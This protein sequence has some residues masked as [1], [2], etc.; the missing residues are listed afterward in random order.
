MATL[1]AD[2]EDVQAAE[3]AQKVDTM[4]DRMDAMEKSIKKMAKRIDDL[5]K[6]IE[7]V[8]QDVN[9]NYVNFKDD[10]LEEYY[11]RQNKNW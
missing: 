3:L 11:D 10:Q 9:Q 6:Y 2:H 1:A 8:Q 7:S 5:D 4:M